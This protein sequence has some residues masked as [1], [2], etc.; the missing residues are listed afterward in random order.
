MSVLM[1][2][3]KNKDNQINTL[4]NLHL[5]KCTKRESRYLDRKRDRQADSYEYKYRYKNERS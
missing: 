2:V 1:K 3:N 4:T 5:Q